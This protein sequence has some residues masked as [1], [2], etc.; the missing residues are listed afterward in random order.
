EDVRFIAHGH[1]TFW[2]VSQKN[3]VAIFDGLKQTTSR[4]VHHKISN[5]ETFVSDLN[6]TGTQRSLFNRVLMRYKEIFG[7]SI[8]EKEETISG[9]IT[10]GKLL[11]DFAAI[12]EERR[13]C[14]VAT[15]RKGLFL[16]PLISRE[17]S[18][19]ILD[20]LE[21]LE[22]AT[23]KESADLERASMA[24]VEKMNE[25]E[26]QINHEITE[27]EREG[28]QQIADTKT[29]VDEE[30]AVLEKD[31]VGEI[32]L[33]MDQFEAAKKVPL[34]NLRTTESDLKGAS[35]QQTSLKSSVKI[36][37]KKRDRVSEKVWKKNL[38]S[39][40]KEMKNLEKER[41]HIIEQ[42]EDLE[43]KKEI[44]IQRCKT[45]FEIQTTE[46]TKPLKDLEAKMK[47]EVESKRAELTE[48]KG[49]FT[50]L[51]GIIEQYKETL[52]QDA[53]KLRE[54]IMSKSIGE[55][56]LLMVPFYISSFESRRK[57]RFVIFSPSTLANKKGILKSLLQRVG[58]SEPTIRARYEGIREL[59]ESKFV[60]SITDE[61]GLRS[62]ISRMGE[63]ANILKDEELKIATDLG[64][65]QLVDRGLISEKKRREISDSLLTKNGL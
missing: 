21:S 58:K 41:R 56:F 31:R 39:T 8:Q 13:R 17:N 15:S 16:N 43:R 34:E 52:K 4:I 45:Y 10:E 44:E 9:L 53:K 1:Y 25:Q 33:I 55:T 48:L 60:Q 30:I 42:I 35:R 3:G 40:E 54:T 37:K 36:S 20:R 28:T 2:I 57:E 5:I 14:D 12:L 23:L 24:L 62:E 26:N 32:K 59:L 49:N 47:T 50:S 63:R 7:S 61:L 46:K 29:I 27:S 38:G 6:A 65:E 64:L 18:G 11:E 51:R 19:E 22:N